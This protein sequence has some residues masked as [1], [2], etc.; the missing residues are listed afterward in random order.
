VVSEVAAAQL[1]ARAAVHAVATA[2]HACIFACRLPV[3]P[4]AM[5]SLTKYVASAM[6]KASFREA[7]AAGGWKVGVQHAF[8]QLVAVAPGC[9]LTRWLLCHHACRFSLTAT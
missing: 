5:G 6:G 2:L 1:A 9:Y 3:W 4:A 7:W 8:P